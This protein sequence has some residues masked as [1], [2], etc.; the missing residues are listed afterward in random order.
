MGKVEELLG[1]EL[2]EEYAALLEKLPSAS[3]MAAPF[4]G[5]LWPVACFL[6]LGAGPSHKQLDRTFELVHEAL[7]PDTLPI[8][9]DDAGNFFCLVVDG[10]LAGHIVWWDHE[11][12]PGDQ[13]VESV[14]PSLAQFISSIKEIG[15]ETG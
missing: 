11:R 4:R 14:V 7:P 5:D 10:S 2:P 8:A 13:K 15:N 12:S 1:S 9:R 3:K 6:E